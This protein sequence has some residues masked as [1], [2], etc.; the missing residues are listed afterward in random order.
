MHHRCLAHAAPVSRCYSRQ[1]QKSRLIVSCSVALPVHIR[2]VEVA[3]KNHGLCANRLPSVGRAVTVTSVLNM[4]LFYFRYVILFPLSVLDGEC[5][6]V[7]YHQLLPFSISLILCV[8]HAFASCVRQVDL[9]SKIFFVND[10]LL[11]N[12]SL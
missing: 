10:R 11:L 2:V 9:T 5:F 1:P 12:T 3:P 7:L 4:P 8:V 6:Y